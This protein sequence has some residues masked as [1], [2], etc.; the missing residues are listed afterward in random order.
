MDPIY[1]PRPDIE[2]QID[3]IQLVLDDLDTK[4]ERMDEALRGNG[5]I[6]IT[7]Q[8]ALLDKRIRGCEQFILEMK[9]LR[10]WLALGILALFGSL[11]WRIIEWYFAQAT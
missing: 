5:S 3:M 11:A 7:T 6:G 10:R 2:A 4:I 8:I 1:R 9:S